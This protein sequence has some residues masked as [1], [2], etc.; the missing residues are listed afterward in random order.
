MNRMQPPAMPLWMLEHLT[1][2]ERDE[3]LAGDLLE[4]FRGGRSNGWFWRQ[5]LGAWLGSWARYFARRRSVLV[6]ALLWS[7]LAP[8]WT[9]V[10]DRVE[11]EVRVI[12][13]SF[14]VP[15]STTLPSLMIWLSLQLLFLSVG[16]VVYFAA[17]ARNRRPPGGILRVCGVAAGLFLPAYFATVILMNLFAWP[18]LEIDRSGMTPLGEIADVRTWAIAIRV[19][20]LVTLL[21][22]MWRVVPR[23]AVARQRTEFGSGV[24]ALEKTRHI[25]REIDPD[26]VWRFFAFVVIAG[27]LNALIAGFLLCRLPESHAPTMASLVIRAAVYIAIGAAAGIMG[28]WVYWNNPASPFREE[29]PLPFALFAMVCAA[30]WLWVPAIVILSEQVTGATALVAAMGAFLL[31]AGLRSTTL[32]VFEQTEPRMPR[33]VKAELFAESL[34]EPPGEV[35]GYFIALCLYAGGWALTGRSNMTAAALLATAAFLFAWIRT[36]ARGRGFEVRREYRRAVVRLACVVIPAVAV[37]TWSLMDGVAHRNHVLAMQAALDAGKDANARKGNARG[38]GGYE[39]VILWPYPEKKQIVAPVPLQDGLLAPGTKQPLVVRF[40]G[41]YWYV[42]P[43]DEQPGPEA[44]QAHGTPLK[45]GIESNNA[46]PLIV[47]A[48][49]GLVA[50]VRLARCREIDVEIENRDESPGA[51]AMELLLTSTNLGH[52]TRLSLGRQTIDS[53]APIAASEQAVGM[54]QVHSAAF[55]TL[56]FAVPAHA[57]IRAFNGVTVVLTPDARHAKVGPR[58]SIR[59][60]QLLPR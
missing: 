33:E 27:L 6:F 4:G 12:G 3:A 21:C 36:G 17:F 53:R 2:A 22:A 30:G 19:P 32:M 1:P 26:T 47:K 20:Y 54:E 59:Q 13:L 49:Q 24:V 37:T 55:E 7:A 10:I 35:H 43:P 15:L 9:A 38:M 8:A 14:N 56:R 39:S 29:A 48:H 41:P 18:G 5:A 34:Y 16:T 52:E 58:I 31:G 40:D 45:V 28:A 23:L 25:A 11:R 60:F 46:L 51:F 50:M 57:T 44:H 42:Q